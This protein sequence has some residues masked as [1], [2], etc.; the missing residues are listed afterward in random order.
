MSILSPSNWSNDEVEI[1]KKRIP[2]MRNALAKS[3]A[4]TAAPTPL[5]DVNPDGMENVQIAAQQRT[6]RINELLNT[7]STDAEV[8]G[9][10]LVN[11]QPLDHPVLQKRTE[12]AA[13]QIPAGNLRPHSD[14]PF[15]PDVLQ[16]SQYANYHQTY[17]RE[18][19]RP[20]MAAAR[21]D[22]RWME[23]MNYIIHLLEQQQN[24]KTNHITEEFVLYTFLGV[25]IIF[26]VDAFSRGGRYVR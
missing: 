3:P 8:G 26:V 16:Q 11:F 7:M 1:P 6:A 21:V 18:A 23:K 19:P 17:E 2:T 22:D 12:D 25:F 14:V 20:A 24:E 15:H 5:I 10:G 13:L 4:P 9:G